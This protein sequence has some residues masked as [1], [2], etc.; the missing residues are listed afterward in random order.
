MMEILIEKS[1][2]RLTLTD[3]EKILFS[4]RIALGKNPTGHKL[5]EGDLRTPEGTYYVCTRNEQSK[6]HLAL[7][8]SY[9]DPADADAALARGEITLEQHA[10]ILSHRTGEMYFVAGTTQGNTLVEAL[11][12]T[13][14]FHTI[15]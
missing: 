12:T 11:A 15:G 8:L 14:F 10:A 1:K 9:P 13:E 4:C 5:R 6:Y 2:C 7:G 3:Q